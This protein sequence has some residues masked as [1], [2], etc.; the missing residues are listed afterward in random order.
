MN[1][2]LLNPQRIII[3]LRGVSNSGKSTFA[4]YLKD[5]FYWNVDKSCEICC[6]DDFFENEKGDYTF[7]ASKLDLAHRLCKNKF[8]K[9]LQNG[10]ELVIVANTNIKPSHFDFYIET[11]KEYG[12]TLFSLVMEKRFEGGDNGHDVPEK[13]LQLMENNIKISL[14]LR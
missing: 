7:D 10:V 12:Y 5:I 4:E 14:K 6:A 9:S 2:K 1:S 3:I 11:A 13:S 8:T